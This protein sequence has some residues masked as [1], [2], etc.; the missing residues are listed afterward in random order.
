M[1]E[2]TYA[3]AKSDGLSDADI[4]EIRRWAKAFA[5]T[6]PPLRPETAEMIAGMFRS[7]AKKSKVASQ[8]A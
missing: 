3:K 5:A 6:A 4:A 1:N 2:E 7:H 8:V